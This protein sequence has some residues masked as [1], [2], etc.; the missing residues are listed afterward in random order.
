MRRY[1][2]RIHNDRVSIH[3][4]DQIGPWFFSNAAADKVRVAVVVCTEV[5][6]TAE[7]AALANSCPTCG[8]P[9]ADIS[10]GAESGK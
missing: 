3:D 2:A 9:R 4:P 7:E 5:P 6:M 8:Q 1:W 10:A